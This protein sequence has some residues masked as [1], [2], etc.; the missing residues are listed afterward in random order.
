MTFF[1]TSIAPLIAL[2]LAA[3]SVQAGEVSALAFLPDSK[4][5][6]AANVDGRLYFLHGITGRELRNVEAHS[7]GAFGLALSPAGDVF[8]S[9]G[10]DGFV[11]LWRV[12]DVEKALASRADPREWCN[13]RTPDDKG[14]ALVGIAFSPDAKTLAAAGYDG[15]VRAW[16]VETGKRCA[17]FQ[18]HASRAIS[19]AFAPDG[20]TLAS[21]GTGP[22]EVRGFGGLHQDENV[23]LWDTT[24]F[25]ELRR[26]ETR[27]HQIAFTPNGHSLASVGDFYKITPNPKGGITFQNDNDVALWDL[28]GRRAIFSHHECQ[29][30]MALSADGKWLATSWG[31]MLHLGGTYVL[32][33]KSRGIR[34]WELA[35][36]KQVLWRKAD[37]DDAVTLAL[38]GDGKRLAAGRKNGTV[39]VHSLA[40]EQWQ[41]GPKVK[42]A[43]HE[44]LWNALRGDDASTAYEAVWNFTATPN[45]A[46]LF[47]KERLRPAPPTD[48]KVK[49]LV[50][51]LD[52]SDFKVRDSAE[53]EL[54]RLG[55][56][57]EPELR[58]VLQGAP[59]AERRRRIELLLDEVSKHPNSPEELRQ[60]R[61]LAVLERIGAG[62][63]HTHLEILADGET[64]AWLTEEA[65]GSLRRLVRR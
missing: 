63:A 57:T 27:A 17:M 39:D 62:E 32:D 45:E 60:L 41:P 35:T 29:H 54:R 40:P 46:S 3:S 48:P 47:L 65:R 42:A 9:A 53:A 14:V 30:A 22:F 20:K 34:L 64:G 37:W 15:K 4:T 55:S 24:T 26:P 2:L 25:K 1:R 5:L 16:E 58:R 51:E 12:A 36:G 43:S 6:V 61:A 38:S 18:A 21:A 19:V 50:A 10:A 8:A 56:A 59:T 7:G 13:L 49:K 11:R 44:A 28:R 52:S 31:S 23:K 33:N